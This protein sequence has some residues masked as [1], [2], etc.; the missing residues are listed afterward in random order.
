VTDE[1][2]AFPL[3]PLEWTDFDHDGLGDNSDADDDNDGVADG[4]DAFPLNAA[5]SV[6][7]DH[8]GTGNNADAD[9]DNDGTP[10]A[11]DPFPLDP[12]NVHPIFTVDSTLDLADAAPGNGVCAT[13]TNECTLRAAVQESNALAGADTIHLT[14]TTITLAADLDVTGTLTIV[15]NGA[16]QTIIQ[17]CDAVANPAC[18]GADRI[19]DVQDGARLTLTALTVRNGGAGGIRV[20]VGGRAGLVLTDAEVLNNTVAAGITAIGE[21]TVTRSRLAGNRVPGGYGG[22]I[23]AQPGTT[24]QIEDSTIEDNS[25][26][27]GGAIFTNSGSAVT[28]FDIVG[29]TFSRNTASWGGALSIN[30]GGPYRIASTTFSHNSATGPE[31]GGAVFADRNF[32]ATSVQLAS[33]TFRENVASQDAAIHAYGANIALRNAIVADSQGGNCVITR[34]GTITSLGYN[35]SDDATCPLAAAGDMT[36]VAAGLAPLANNGGLTQTHA[37]L[38]TSPAI[39]AG[40]PTG[41]TDATGAALMSDQ[42]GP[43]FPRAV[44]GDSDGVARCDIGAVEGVGMTADYDGDGVPDVNDAYPLDATESADTDGDGIGN[45]ADPNDDNDGL[46]DADDPFP[47]DPLNIGPTPA[48]ISDQAGNSVAVLDTAANTVTASISLGAPFGY[49][50]RPLG[51]AVPASGNRVYVANVGNFLRGAGFVS[52][53]DGATNTVVGAITGTGE[54]FPLMLCGVHGI[55]TNREGTRLYFGHVPACGGGPSGTSIVVVDTATN[56]VIATVPAGS[57]VPT[58]IAV[59]PAGTKVYMAVEFDNAVWVLDTATHA[60][61]RIPVGRIPYGVA[62]NPAGTRVYVGNLDDHSVSVIDTASNTVIATV[63]VGAGPSAVAVNREGTELYVTNTHEH[64]VSVVDT[65]S[66]TV[67]ATI[68]V[69]VGP[70]GVA[71]NPG[72]TRA[73]VVNS[74]SDTAWTGRRGLA[75]IGPTSISVLDTSTRA[76][77]ASV[78]G[79]ISQLVYGEFIAMGVPDGDLDGVPDATDAFPLDPSET[80]DTDGDGTGNHADPD[81]DNDGIEDA[82]DDGTDSSGR[83]RYRSGLYTFGSVS[84][85][86]WRVHMTDLPGG[87]VQA[88]LEAIPGVTAERAFITACGGAYKDIQ[89][90]SAGESVRWSCDS[91]ATLSLAAVVANPTIEVAKVVCGGDT[92]NYRILAALASGQSFSTGSPATA[93][94]G[95]EGPIPVTILDEAGVPIG[96]FALD[97]GESVSVEVLIDTNGQPHVLLRLEKGV[98]EVTVFGQTDTLTSTHSEG[99]FQRDTQPPVIDGVSDVTAEA[100]STAGAVV[101]FDAPAVTDDVD[102]TPTVTISHASGTT[103][104]L[105]ETVVTVTASDDAEHSASRT[106]TVSVVDTTPPAISAP[107]NLTIEATSADGAPATF[108]ATASDTAGTPGITYSH[109]P[110]S[111]FPLGTTTVIATAVDGSGNQASA[112]FTVTVRDTQAPVIAGVSIDRPELWPANHRMAAVTLSYHVSD[113]ADAAPTCSL[114]VR[115]NEPENGTGDGDAAPDWQVVDARQVFLRAERSGQGIGRVYSIDLTCTDASGNR[116]SAQ[117]FVTVPRSRR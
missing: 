78:A 39:D 47:L 113:V 12:L 117:A 76:V 29:S 27:V 24:L 104:P 51:V 114:S 15:G 95:N 93:G 41:C 83:N 71:F 55:A 43:G 6:D 112:T 8:D 21:V 80:T 67:L 94:I 64:T 86:G 2:D 46:P 99:D 66:N 13:A 82:I 60:T 34:V 62:V 45:H 5:E 107:P 17:G 84:P 96:S 4:S 23:Q 30:G 38:G 16:G 69:G 7:T 40:D 97:A 54:S 102:P 35:L 14:G 9:D 36:G 44:D 108:A 1:A 70:V 48:Y 90:E 98:V 74:G 58:G 85:N 79:G 19:F 110:G 37:L 50:P 32:A 52:V 22:A 28:S 42:R 63:A 68:G 103:F 115:S 101:S 87:E 26:A 106:F 31:G 33:V 75:L 109:P 91:H 81:D 20:G 100:T 57:G 88:T 59:N 11:S 111:T 25:A 65:A 92:C 73:Y 105:G 72:G 3:N 56:A 53:I 77:I 18:V 10:D 49:A 61:A 89:L 116:S